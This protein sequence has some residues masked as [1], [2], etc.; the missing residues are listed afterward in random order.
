MTD[1][2]ADKPSES[3]AEGQAA[4]EDLDAMFP[5]ENEHARRPRHT[6]QQPT[7]PAGATNQNSASQK[8]SS[9]TDMDKMESLL[10]ESQTEEEMLGMPPYR[11]A[12]YTRPVTEP[13]FPEAPAYDLTA[14]SDVDLDSMESLLDL[15]SAK[16]VPS[17]TQGKPKDESEY[18]DIF[19]ATNDSSSLEGGAG[20]HYEDLHEDSPASG[21]RIQLTEDDYADRFFPGRSEEPSRET[22]SEDSG[23]EAEAESSASRLP[24]E[25]AAASSSPGALKSRTN[26]GILLGLLG[27]IGSALALWMNLGISDRVAHLETQRIAQAPA[28]KTHDQ[29]AAIASLNH[30]L[31]EL[32][33]QFAAHMKQV[34]QTE[35]GSAPT[36]PAAQAA[37]EKP[38]A[39]VTVPAQPAAQTAPEKPAATKPAVPAA[40]PAQ[41][42]AAASA[43]PSPATKPMVVAQSPKGGEWVVNLSSY[44]T[45]AA[46]G[47]ELARLKKLGIQAESVKVGV[48][49]RTW[50]RLR[51]LGYASEKE[52]REQLKIVEKQ[53]GITDA[54]IGVR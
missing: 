34:A 48:N 18:L 11:G 22:G 53:V 21:K 33:G 17:A 28:V 7:P 45:P 19:D 26:I 54:W 2:A 51:A 30:R 20:A 43:K 27:V 52:A 39:P 9:Y 10:D 1:H 23:R 12:G 24:E 37:P 47:R 46:A 8:F 3:K 38:A 5:D 44:S 31:D 15:E 14:D 32:S 41:P 6:G 35:A 4:A 42:A 16:S 36:A 25:P 29:S 40:V 50:Y 13:A 49:G